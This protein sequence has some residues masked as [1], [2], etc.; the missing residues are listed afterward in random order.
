[1]AK[2]IENGDTA[3]DTQTRPNFAGDWTFLK[4]RSDWGSLSPP[5][6]MVR[7]VRQ[8]DPDFIFTDRIGT[9]AQYYKYRTDGE[10]TTFAVNT[11]QSNE[12][13]ARWVGRE[14]HI[15]YVSTIGDPKSSPTVYKGE[16]VWT[17][18]PDGRT[19]TVRKEFGHPNGGGDRNKLVSVFERK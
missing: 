5:D 12:G 4:A 11:G 10:R 2:Q 13:S 7:S 9:S 19:L 18:E 17:L 14:L 3:A 16:E 15:D 8:R 6:A 1:M